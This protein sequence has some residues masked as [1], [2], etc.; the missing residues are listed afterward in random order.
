[1]QL[2][3]AD[4][5]TLQY[6]YLPNFFSPENMKKRL[7]K[8]AHNQPKTFFSTATGPKSAQISYSVPSKWFPAR[9]IYN[10]FASTTIYLTRL[11]F[12]RLY[13]LKR[14]FYLS[15]VRHEII[16]KCNMNKLKIRKL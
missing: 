13:G 14:G 16:E 1:M 6:L 2:F 8:V 5:Q 7:S 3:S 15:K 9:L 10:D 11:E 4:L 12:Y